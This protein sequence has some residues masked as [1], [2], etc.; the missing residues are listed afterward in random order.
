MTDRPGIPRLPGYTDVV[1]IARG[2][3]A[4]VL[5][6]YNERLAR[7]E[8]I[9]IYVPDP[10]NT[11]AVDRARR[12]FDDEARITG[13]QRNSHI[14]VVHRSEVHDGTPCLFMEFVDGQSLRALL[15]D[16][17]TRLSLP[18][19]VSILADIADALD[20]LA[21]SPIPV[22]HR[23]VKPDNILLERDADGVGRAV[24]ADFG[25]AT[26]ITGS[27]TVTDRV[28]TPRYAAPEQLVGTSPDP[29][30]DQYALACTAY[31]LLTG[32]SPHREA[33]I[34]DRLRR[35]ATGE[36]EPVRSLTGVNRRLRRADRVF[37]RALARN[38]ARR[39]PTSTAFVTDLTVALGMTGLGTCGRAVAAARRHPRIA[40]V[41]VAATALGLVAS[42]VVG[43]RSVA[44]LRDPARP[45]L[46]RPGLYAPCPDLE[47]FGF[48]PDPR[49]SADTP[50][51]SPS[52]DQLSVV[53]GFGAF[54]VVDPYDGQDRRD[55][56]GRF[57][58]PEVFRLDAKS[59]LVP[60]SIVAT[61]DSERG[62]PYGAS[63]RFLQ[64]V[65]SPPD[66][67]VLTIYSGA[68]PIQAARLNRDFEQELMLEPPRTRVVG[69]DDDHKA[70]FTTWSATRP[71]YDT[72]T[73]RLTGH[74]GADAAPLLI[75]HQARELT[76]AAC[77][78]LTDL[79]DHQLRSAWTT[80]SPG[81]RRDAVRPVSTKPAAAG[82]AMWST[83]LDGTRPCGDHAAVGLRLRGPVASAVHGT[84]C[85]F[86]TGGGQRVAVFHTD[87]ASA[88]GMVGEPDALTLD[89]DRVEGT[90]VS[91]HSFGSEPVP[92]VWVANR[93][94]DD[95][96]RRAED[97]QGRYLLMAMIGRAV[98]SRAVR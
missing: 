52:T 95:A 46:A 64:D 39:Y 23:D 3:Q 77:D 92:V 71:P 91:T 16:A 83:V 59:V 45:I 44:D 7:F 35:I 31:E 86:E 43:Y 51:G 54:E 97:N 55:T 49:F 26:R 28:G 56:R 17:D 58:T 65:D 32:G 61:A 19:I 82:Q 87:A 9:K 89:G 90:V 48:T 41:A 63:C 40:A 1:E 76:P 34:E 47:S 60:A 94:D 24:L 88:P 12:R 79:L 66:G 30:S 42:G 74:D 11:V 33:S 21:G 18:Q 20:Q 80:M 69:L 6:A 81:Q 14:I 70:T 22:V 29:R 67:A 84:G 73:A 75:L 93:A 38:P 15:D 37:D 68:D 98:G 57:I 25:V 62:L 78:K 53:G 8:A 72:C 13:G 27:D 85:W 4:R 50:A 10:D 96:L 36:V 5:R 2:G